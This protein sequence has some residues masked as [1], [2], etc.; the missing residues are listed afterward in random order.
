MYILC[1]GMI[2]ARI[3][4]YRNVITPMNWCQTDAS[5][6]LQLVSQLPR[7]CLPYCRRLHAQ[8]LYST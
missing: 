2:T 6:A 4:L 5:H 3:R 8:S 7:S 1:E